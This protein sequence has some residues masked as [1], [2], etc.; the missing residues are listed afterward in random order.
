MIGSGIGIF[1]KRYEQ[2]PNDEIENNQ[3]EDVALFG[4]HVSLDSD[5][6][7]CIS[8]GD[9]YITLGSLDDALSCAQLI[10]QRCVDIHHVPLEY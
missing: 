10:R 3:E 8:Q 6:P 5:M 7:E 9:M 2:L 4:Y 1:K